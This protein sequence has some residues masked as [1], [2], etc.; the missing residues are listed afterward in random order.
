MAGV[1]CDG[2]TYHRS[3]VARDRD[4]TRQ[5]VLEGLGW[6]LCRVWSTDW[7]YDARSA[8]DRLHAE[9]NDLLDH[10]RTD[11]VDEQG[12]TDTPHPTSPPP[13]LSPEST[14]REPTNR[15]PTDRE[16]SREADDNEPAINSS[17]ARESLVARL[18]PETKSIYQ[19][20][21]LPD[22]SDQQDRFY[23]DDYA[24]KLQTL[25]R[26]VIQVEGPIRDD[27]LVRRIARAH[28]FARTGNKINQA[29]L[30]TITDVTKTTES[31]GDFLWPGGDVP[32]QIPFRH[33][34]ASAAEE[35]T[36]AEIPI[37][38]LR[39]LLSENTDCLADDDPALSL[40]R[41][42]GLSRLSR[43]ARERLESIIENESVGPHGAG[44]P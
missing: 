17:A 36:L 6:N 23:D 16:P 18:T 11:S 37:Q 3:A 20:E 24:P 22:L 34:A 9:L 1:E 13:T 38:E 12:A 14:D 28:G 33:P 30:G 26:R 29:V 2:A 39:G 10:S 32:R 40:A 15:E 8:T 27:V 25:A 43:A 35:R 7:W 21:T 4:K 42:F 44:S 31:T 5:L 19:I 41:R